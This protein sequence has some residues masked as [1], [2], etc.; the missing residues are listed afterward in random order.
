M[1]LWQQIF[2]ILEGII[3]RPQPHAGGGVRR[4]NTVLIQGADR[5]RH[6]VAKDVSEKAS[7]LVG[8]E[9][10]VRQWRPSPVATV[11]P[12]GPC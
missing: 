5:Q 8:S 2:A 9:S 12:S 6:G 3:R 1:V 7:F 11:R 4:R 10:N